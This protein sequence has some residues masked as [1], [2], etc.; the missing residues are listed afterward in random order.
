MASNYDYIIEKIKE[1]CP[2][3]GRFL[4]FGCGA[5][6]VVE[7]GLDAGL[8]YYGADPYAEHYSNYRDQAQRDRKAVTEKI[9]QIKDGVLPF[10]DNHFDAVSSNMVFEH[11]ENAE[12]ALSE[13]HRVLKPGGL[14]LAL[15]PTKETWWEGHAK[16]YFAHW[17]KPH[18]K[19]QY[20]YL[21]TLKTIGIG[22]DN[23]HKTPATWATYFQGY[24]VRSCFYRRM[25]EIN[26]LWGNAFGEKPNTHEYDYM[27]YRLQKSAKLSRLVPVLKNPLG[28]AFLVQACKI[29]A[30]RVLSIHKDAGHSNA[31]AQK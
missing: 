1:A 3:D 7:R 26:A 12:Q 30:G 31:A 10:P 17:M 21:K 25:G 27:L 13:I 9:S 24:F 14:F 29:R 19:L 16:I 2:K 15:F 6:Q 28:K 5:G 8:D 23:D 4:D 22:K 20:H 11:V 18:S